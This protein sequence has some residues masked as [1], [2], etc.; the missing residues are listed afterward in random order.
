MEEDS[1]KSVAKSG[2]FRNWPL[3]KLETGER[4]VW[5][6]KFAR[7]PSM[8][9]SGFLQHFGQLLGFQAGYRRD[10]S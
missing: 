4:C 6:T 9:K 2:S 10:R 3:P 7:F 1:L 5:M 8:T